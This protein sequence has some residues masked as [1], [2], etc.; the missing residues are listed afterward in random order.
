[1]L[2]YTMRLVKEKTPLWAWN[3]AW[4]MKPCKHKQAAYILACV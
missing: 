4:M 2:A 1:M 3:N